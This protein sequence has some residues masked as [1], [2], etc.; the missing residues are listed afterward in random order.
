MLAKTI[1]NTLRKIYSRFGS[2]IRQMLIYLLLALISIYVAMGAILYAFQ[3]SFVYFPDRQIVSNPHNIDLPYDAVT[4]SAQDGVELFGWFVPALRERAVI[5]FCHGNAGNISDRL[6]YIKMFNALDFSVFAFDYRGY[7]RSHGEPSE[8]GTYLDAQAAWDYLTQ[9]RGVSPGDIV[10]FGES[11]GGAIGAWLAQ[12][13]DPAALIIQA[14]FISIPAMASHLYPMFPAR[15]LARY[16]YSTIDYLRQVRVP[17]LIAHSC[18][19]DIIPFDQGMKLYEAAKEPKQFLEMRGDHNTG[20]VS[21][22][23]T[24]AD[25]INEFLSKYIRR[26]ITQRKQLGTLEESI[27]MN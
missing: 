6:Q 16:S 5:L 27:K 1:Q 8:Q 4:F 3:S 23:K 14:A 9:K 11:L 7:G 19:D 17:V 22:G 2:E 26:Q 15:F 20:Y 25:G 10:I 24:Y 21:S 13:K 12:N 18:D